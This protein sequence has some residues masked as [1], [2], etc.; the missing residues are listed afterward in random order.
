[1]IE[2]PP[3]LHCTFFFL[4]SFYIHSFHSFPFQFIKK[5]S[6]RLDD[7]NHTSC[8]RHYVLLCMIVSFLGGNFAFCHY[9]KRFLKCHSICCRCGTFASH[10]SA[11]HHHKKIKYVL[12][13][14]R[15]CTWV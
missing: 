9:V 11:L 6:A 5:L 2:C 3:H 7:Y 12:R 10:M 15:Y 8:F 13:C 4:L 14:T 1:M